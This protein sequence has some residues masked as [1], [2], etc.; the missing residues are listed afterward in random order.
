MKY[1]PNYMGIITNHD[2]GSILNNQDLAW[3]VSGRFFS[4]RLF[5][6]L[7]TLSLAISLAIKAVVGIDFEMPSTCH[8]YVS[9][10]AWLPPSVLQKP[11]VSGIA[12]LLC[13]VRQTWSWKMLTCWKLNQFWSFFSPL[14]AYAD[15]P[16]QGEEGD[17]NGGG[18]FMS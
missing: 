6:L 3:K 7:L 16:V 17:G 10:E 2:K 1:Y 5:V 14:E 4:A 11:S 13:K 15:S 8:Q 12:K 9:L 18:T